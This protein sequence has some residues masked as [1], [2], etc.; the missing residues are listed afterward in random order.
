M[1]ER[2]TLKLLLLLATSLAI[3]SPAV[4]QS[5]SLDDRG[6]LG[7]DENPQFFPTEVF[8]SNH[9]ILARVY[10]RYLRLM[11]EKP[12]AES[13]SPECP[14]VYRVL[15]ETR[16]YNAPVIVRLR[17]RTDGVC[18]LVAKVGRDSGHP[19]ILTVNK[20]TDPSRLD[21]EKFLKLLE[22]AGFWSMPRQKPFDIHHVVMGD[23]GWMLEGIKGRRY[24]LVHRGTSELG[25]LKDSVAFL[26][27][28]LANLDLRSLPVGPQGGR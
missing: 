24:H 10:S 3:A 5:Q 4:A 17:I 25:S 1:T 6:G 15:V 13:A 11:A 18:E 22:E 7:P 26:V 23:A 20:T 19:Q 27:T 16:P 12:L 21:V 14:Q 8:G 9:A 2:G 28:N